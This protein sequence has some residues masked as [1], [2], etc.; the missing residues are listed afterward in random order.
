MF[1]G[2]IPRA[3]YDLSVGAGVTVQRADDTTPA[4]GPGE[5]VHLQ[6]GDVLTVPGELLH[7]ELQ[8]TDGPPRRRRKPSPVVVPAVT[9][10]ALP[11]NDSDPA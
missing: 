8:P 5:T 4:P 11:P 7:C 3:F 1:T 10:I 2:G 9:P 6:P